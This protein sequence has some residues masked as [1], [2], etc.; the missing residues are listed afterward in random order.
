MKALGIL[1]TYYTVTKFDEPEVNFVVD[2]EKLV[3]E[4]IAELET[5]ETR[6]KE[7]ETV[8]TCA[9]CK[10]S[11][12]DEGACTILGYITF[13]TGLSEDT[14]LCNQYKPKN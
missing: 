10:K 8:K 9:S 4:A 7:L 5:M 11:Y 6:I 13:E 14:F 12:G 1:K 3:I 2:N